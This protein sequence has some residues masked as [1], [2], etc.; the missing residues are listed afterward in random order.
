ML[1]W[2][3]RAL[4]GRP[5]TLRVH[6]R[7]CRAAPH[8]NPRKAAEDCP[9]RV[10]SIDEPRRSCS[11]FS[12]STSAARWTTHNSKQ[13]EPRRYPVPVLATARQEQASDFDEWQDGAVWT[14]LEDPRYTV[15]AFFR[16]WT[17][18]E[19]LLDVGAGHVMRFRKAATDRVVRSR[20]KAH[21]HARS[22]SGSGVAIKGGW[23]LLSSKESRTVRS[24]QSA[25]TR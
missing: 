24:E 6:G 19:M 10:L 18:Q 20:A 15:F 25:C 12:P 3:T 22:C 5:G 21:P 13:P 8:P 17:R 16:R 9:L 14:I 4:P 1:E 7:R 11:G 23:R 2:S